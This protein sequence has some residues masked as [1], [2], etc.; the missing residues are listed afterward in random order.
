[1]TPPSMRPSHSPPASPA[2]LRLRQAISHKV[3]GRDTDHAPR[4]STIDLVLCALYT[5]GHVLLEDYPGSG[6]SYLA[7]CLG[8]SLLHD[9]P[10]HS[11]A[12]D[13]DSVHV[14]L[15]QFRRIQCTPDLLPSDLTGYYDMHRTF[16]PGPVFSTVVLVDE[17]N[18]TT[19]RVQSALLEA[20]AEKQVT[21]ENKSHPL[22]ELFFGIATQNPLDHLGTFEL[23]AAQLDRFLFKRTL[24]PVSDECEMRI[25]SMDD[26]RESARL[27]PFSQ[28]QAHAGSDFHAYPVTVG[29][30]LAERT[31]IN[32]SVTCHPDLVRIMVEIAG[33]LQ[34]RFSGVPVYRTS[35]RSQKNLFNCLK[36]VAF[37]EHLLHGHELTVHP[38]LLPLIAEDFY[39]HRLGLPTDFDEFD[40]REAVY[41]TVV[42]I[43]ERAKL[44]PS[45]S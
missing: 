42:E 12:A 20:M 23:P 31:W 3:F 33:A 15:A 17:I 26:P 7:E 25:I 37:A 1:M 8:R 24:Q 9:A 10:G 43:I 16:H 34:H 38:R 41:Q 40:P 21:V 29:Q 5:G 2:Y 14:P 35:A 22:G 4:L 18:R 44:S 27:P 11:A 30:V 32:A 13:P 45:A 36:V 39:L 28:T 19:P 6:K